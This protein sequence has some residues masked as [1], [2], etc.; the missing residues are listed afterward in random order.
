MK[1][2]DS[3]ATEAASIVALRRDIHAHPELCFQENRTADLVAAQ[4]ASWGIEVHRGMG[5]TGVVGVIKNGT[6]TRSI[7]LRADMDALPIQEATGKP[8]ASQHAGVM[9][10]CGH[11]GHTAILLGAAEH[12][13]KTRRFSGTV[14]LVFQPAEEAG[15]G[16]GAGGKTAAQAAAAS[17]Q[18]AAVY[19]PA[20]AHEPCVAKQSELVGDSRLADAEELS[21]VAHTPLV[22]RKDV[23]E[24]DAGRVPEHLEGVGA[25]VGFGAHLVDAGAQRVNGGRDAEIGG[26]VD[27]QLPDLFDRTTVAEGHGEVRLVVAVEVSHGQTDW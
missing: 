23:E 1:L 17:A 26:S 16:S 20:L 5:T 22:M 15:K 13:A 12:L 25:Q 3:I 18:R 7:G 6:S 24:T 27:E 4:L 21:Q 11:D 2:L 19:A 14:Q 9:H 8:Y 10:A